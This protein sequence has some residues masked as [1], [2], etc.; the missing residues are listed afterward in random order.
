MDF[1]RSG[2]ISKPVLIDDHFFDRLS[3]ILNAVIAEEI[4]VIQ[5][6]YGLSAGQIA[7]VI[8]GE[9]PD[10]LVDYRA[11]AARRALGHASQIKFRLNFEGGHSISSAS[12]ASVK[13]TLLREPESPTTLNVS[14][15]TSA[16][17]MIDLTFRNHSETTRYFLMGRRRDVE[18][19][20]TLVNNLVEVSQPP[21]PWS[22]S[23][24]VQGISLVLLSGA[25]VNA[26]LITA[27][28]ISWVKSLNDAAAATLIAVIYMVQMAILWKLFDIVRD[29]LPFVEISY[30]L[31]S[32]KRNQ[33]R[34]AIAAAFV[35][36][37][38]PILVG[39]GISMF[40]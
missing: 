21:Q 27:R 39:V 7:T 6:E 4:A 15:G 38:C 22:R 36:L 20:M 37:V 32:R 10:G 11:D 34:R 1:T 35:L 24:W 23:Q 13:E 19:Y 40:S 29:A 25:A 12:F 16:T 5:S 26:A 3:D 31:Q 18:H 17:T 30:G 8:A 2:V 33:R 28:Q 9:N 14:A